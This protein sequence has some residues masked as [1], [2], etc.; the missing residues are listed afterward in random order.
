M[1][2]VRGSIRHNMREIET[3]NADKNKK[4]VILDMTPEQKYLE[5]YQEKLGDHKPRKNA[6]HGIEVLCSASPDFFNKDNINQWTNQTKKW[7]EQKFEGHQNIVQMILHLD[8]KTPHVHAVI[9]PMK[10]KKLNANSFIGGGKK[11]LSYLQDSYYSSVKN[12][13]LERGQKKSKAIHQDIQ[14]YYTKINE[15]VKTFNQVS[16]ELR[17]KLKSK[18]FGRDKLNMDLIIEYI[19]K[20]DN[21]INQLNQDKKE[22]IKDANEK[23]RGAAKKLKEL[24]YE[25]EELYKIQEETRELRKEKRLIEK[26]LK[27][28]NINYDNFLKDAKNLE[29]QRKEIDKDFSR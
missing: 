26:L 14:T 7:I 18:K 11:T 17:E 2:Q 13:G 16:S 6:V 23:I 3:P 27:Y 5:E 22:I 24:K 29:I 9:I 8:E 10:N 15:E 19:T 21:K 12:L 25:N 1:Q 4:N 28:Q 20:A